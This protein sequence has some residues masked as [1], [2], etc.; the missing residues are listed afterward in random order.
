MAKRIF[1]KCPR[2]LI[3]RFGQNYFR[4]RVLSTKRRGRGMRVPAKAEQ[5]LTRSKFPQLA[6]GQQQS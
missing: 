6:G 5:V 1:G 4:G 3:R 2:T